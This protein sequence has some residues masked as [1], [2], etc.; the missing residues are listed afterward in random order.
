MMQEYHL[1]KVENDQGESIYHLN[2]STIIIGRDT[3]SG[4]KVYDKYMMP[5]HAI[6]RRISTAD[7]NT[8]YKLILG[9]GPVALYSNKEWTDYALFHKTLVTG[10]IF[11]LGKT[12]FSYMIA[13]MTPAEYSQH[14]NAQPIVLNKVN[15]HASLIPS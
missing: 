14:F 3:A 12:R 15:T 8:A 11:Q 4:I 5:H 7:S 13:H 1:L 6:L 2:T 9:E 10:D